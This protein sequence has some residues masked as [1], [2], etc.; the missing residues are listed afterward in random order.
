MTTVTPDLSPFFV[1]IEG[2][3]KVNKGFSIPSIGIFKLKK[4]KKII[5]INFPPEI[6][7]LPLEN[8]EAL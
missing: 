6:L 8:L 1:I 5:R 4:I 7:Y 2:E 3:A